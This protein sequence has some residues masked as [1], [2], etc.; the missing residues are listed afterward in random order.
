M[1]GKSV[2]AR[3][4][5]VPAIAVSNDAVRAFALAEKS[6]SIR[7]GYRSDFSG[8]SRWCSAQGVETLPATIN[9]VVAFLAAEAMDGRKPSTLSRKMAAIRYAHR[10]AEVPDPT[11]S[12]R[13]KAVL[14]GIRREK[15]TAPCQKGFCHKFVSWPR[16]I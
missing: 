8:F 12:E 2:S 1:V 11:D 14:R 6:E 16:A 15:G 3:V 10:L 13:T 4:T 7:R 5:A 9:T